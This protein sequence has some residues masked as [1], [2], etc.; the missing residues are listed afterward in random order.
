MA[1]VSGYLRDIKVDIGDRVHTGQLLA[2]IEVPE[3]EDDLLK[4]AA[5]IDEASAD[6]A[7][8]RDELKRSQFAY[9]IAHLSYGRIL[10]V[11]RR[12]PGL[13]PQQ[14]VDEAQ[15]RNLEADAQVA[16][17]KSRI[18]A[19][20]QRIRVARAEEARIKT[21]QQYTV[22]T[23]PFDGVI[24]K[25]Y[26][27]VSAMIQTGIASQ[28]QAMPVVRLSENG[29]LRLVLPV[30]ESAVAD[31]RLGQTVMVSVSVINQT[32]SGRVARFADS[33]QLST[34]TMDAE[35]DVPNPGLVLIPGM[36]AEV[37]LTLQRHNNALTVPLDAID[38]AGSNSPR[39]FVI[40]TDR[41]IHIVGVTTGLE[42]SERTEIL[43]GVQEGETVVAGRHSD[44][45]EGERVHAKLVD[46][47]GAA[48]SRKDH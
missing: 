27:N 1:K 6:L 39:A 26:A 14:E 21:L 19:S 42:T 7:T 23:A 34:R 36:Y 45:R 13:V 31:I 30:P 43:T 41:I 15:A 2:T 22:I 4:A 17:A 44:L 47:D 9:D 20:E 38:G 8:A 35:V 3:L 25:R 37:R 46:L 28:T 48:G 12:E 33:L 10:D 11:A 40:G 5:T 24:T 16:S 32:F 18:G 29:L